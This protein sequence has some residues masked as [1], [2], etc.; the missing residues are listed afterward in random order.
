[1]FGYVILDLYILRFILNIFILALNELSKR[2]L[3]E[4]SKRALNE[5]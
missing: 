3:N 1:M 4:L 2:A 5:L